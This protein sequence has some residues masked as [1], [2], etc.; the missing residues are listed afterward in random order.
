MT[1]EQRIQAQI[2]QLGRDNEWLAEMLR[3][4]RLVSQALRGSSSILRRK[5]LDLAQSILREER[6]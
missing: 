6:P 2:N 1:H 4:S 5:A 3:T